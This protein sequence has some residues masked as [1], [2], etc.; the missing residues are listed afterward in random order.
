MTAGAGLQ[1]PHRWRDGTSLAAVA[2]LHDAG[3]DAYNGVV[4]PRAAECLVWLN[5]RCLAVWN[6]L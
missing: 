1:H 2:V 4:T 5:R 3:A 6:R